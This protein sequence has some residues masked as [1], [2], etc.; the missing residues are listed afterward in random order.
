MNNI[1]KSTRAVYLDWIMLRERMHGASLDAL[2]HQYGIST[3]TVSSHVKRA[4]IDLQ[5]M[6]MQET[7]GD[8]ESPRISLFTLDQFNRDPQA[9]RMQMLDDII[10]KLERAYPA[11]KT[12]LDTARTNA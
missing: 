1:H 7:Q 8:P 12:D 11:L 2:A 4:F 9:C 6:V 5:V 10:G 3:R